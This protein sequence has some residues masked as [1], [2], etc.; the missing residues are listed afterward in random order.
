M[1]SVEATDSECA[2]HPQRVWRV[3]TPA[4]YFGGKMRNI[5]KGVGTGSGGRRGCQ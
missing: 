1:S 5:F 4:P 2:G 3:Q